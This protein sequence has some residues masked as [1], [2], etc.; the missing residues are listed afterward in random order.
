MPVTEWTKWMTSTQPYHT[1]RYDRS[2]IVSSLDWTV[3]QEFS[4]YRPSTV[5][6]IS[7]DQLS[8]SPVYS[9]SSHFSGNFQPTRASIDTTG[10]GWAAKYDPSW[11]QMTLPT[12]YVVV[13]VYIKQR[14]DIWQY[15]TRVKI[16]KSADGASW[17]TVIESENLSY[18]SYD[19]QGYCSAW[20]AQA[21]GDRFWSI[22]V[23]A[24]YL[25]AAMR[26]DLIGYQ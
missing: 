9:A 10:C 1:F 23:I 16:T 17:Q 21:Y 8:P 2:L 26:A 5:Y 15:P 24:A 20:F 22:H 12:E 19:K 6:I 3:L 7:N 13:G 18:D 4:R 14:C 25:H 11:L